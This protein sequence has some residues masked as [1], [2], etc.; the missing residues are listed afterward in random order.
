MGLWN[1]QRA[2]RKSSQ[3]FRT[4][5]HKLQISSNEGKIKTQRKESFRLREATQ[6]L[7][8]NV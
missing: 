4:E 2:M 1:K 8:A 7:T 6:A 3:E 5:L